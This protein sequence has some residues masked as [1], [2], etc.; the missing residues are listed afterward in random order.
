[1]VEAESEYKQSNYSAINCDVLTRFVLD[2][3]SQW[4]TIANPPDARAPNQNLS[5]RSGLST[6]EGAQLTSPD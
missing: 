4:L 2:H 1:M 5:A 6:T 3:F